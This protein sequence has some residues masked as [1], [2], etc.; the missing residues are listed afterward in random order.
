MTWYNQLEHGP[1]GDAD[2]AVDY[3][4]DEEC[5]TFCKN[6]GILNEKS[7]PCDCRGTKVW[8]GPI[9]NQCMLSIE[10]CAKE[11]LIFDEN[12]CQCIKSDKL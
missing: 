10:V 4:C 11:N 8:G 3:Y 12:D 9:C 1:C 5:V 6:G 2:I 7:C